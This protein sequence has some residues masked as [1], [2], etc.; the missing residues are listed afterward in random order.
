MSV[1]AP[2]VCPG[3]LLPKY[4]KEESNYEV[5]VEITIVNI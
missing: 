3:K 2:G 1:K 5:G 4:G